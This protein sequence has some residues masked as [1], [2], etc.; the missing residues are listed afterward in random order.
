MEAF[1]L[2]MALTAFSTS[3]L[4]LLKFI[5]DFETET[6]SSPRIASLSDAKYISFFFTYQD[7]DMPA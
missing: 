7:F 1:Q 6:F 4:T 2:V 5:F 3:L